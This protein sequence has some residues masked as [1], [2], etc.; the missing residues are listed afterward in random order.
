M[1]FTKIMK[2]SVFLILFILYTG[3]LLAQKK[4]AIESYSQKFYKIGNQIYGIKSLK[5]FP[6]ADLYTISIDKKGKP[7][8]IFP[9]Q[10]I[11]ILNSYYKNVRWDINENFYINMLYQSSIEIGGERNDIEFYE[12]AKMKKWLEISTVT[13]K[14]NMVDEIYKKDY[15]EKTVLSHN[16]TSIQDFYYKRALGSR[17]D[18]WHYDMILKKDETLLMPVAYKDSLYFYTFTDKAWTK[19]DYQGVEK[20]KENDKWTRTSQAKHDFKTGFRAFQ[21]K[22]DTYF[23]TN[24]DTM[25][26]KYENKALKEIGRIKPI[27][28]ER[29]LFLI[30]K[31][32]DK[33]YF[34]MCENIDVIPEERKRFVLLRKEDELYK[35]IKRIIDEPYRK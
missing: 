19:P 28:A 23:L 6:Q 8:W 30:D 3:I 22:D 33:V 9:P 10:G 16:L 31:D 2:K 26:Y 32:D 15:A 14:S 17:K 24:A 11:I 12:R 35:A 20:N 29:T 13:N 21:I 34:L 25:I 7:K 18:Y 1:E 4:E 5:R 27:Q